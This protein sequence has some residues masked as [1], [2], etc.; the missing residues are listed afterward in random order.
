MFQSNPKFILRSGF[1]Y[2]LIR[3]FENNSKSQSNQLGSQINKLP[4]NR[5]NI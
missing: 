4:H 3:T 5:I 2:L 1:G